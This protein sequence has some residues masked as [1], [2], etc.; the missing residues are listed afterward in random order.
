MDIQQLE[1]FAAAARTQ[2]I[3][4]A[5]AEM[6]VSQPAVSVAIRKLEEELGI[7][8][9]DRLGGRVVLTEAGRV[10][11]RRTGLAFQELNEAI[12]QLSDMRGDRERRATVYGTSLGLCSTLFYE[13]FKSHKPMKLEYF[14][15]HD[16]IIV[17]DLYKGV[18]DFAV[19]TREIRGNGLVYRQ[20]L[21][22]QP[23]VLL[24]PDHP[25]A[26]QPYVE[27]A[28]LEGERFIRQR[29]NDKEEQE[30]GVAVP[31][32]SRPGS[33]IET[34]EFSVAVNMVSAGQGVMVVSFNS[35]SMLFPG[36]D[37]RIRALPIRADRPVRCIGVV[38]RQGHY[39][40]RA[41][42]ELYDFTVDYFTAQ[43]EL[44]KQYLDSVGC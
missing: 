12:S 39:F 1:Y 34:N 18:V 11:M 2:N 14:I 28:Q 15:H 8:L 26:A 25:L 4:R 20:L 22:E 44:Q 9:F 24:P 38:S 41:V 32:G 23:F 5:A 31:G 33:T 40:S 16:A 6:H 36:T 17:E 19:C 7:A 42:Q 30:Y 29:F 35:A 27:M 43:G 21:A 13:F 3:T 10:L 37:D